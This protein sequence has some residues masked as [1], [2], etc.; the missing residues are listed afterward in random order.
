M[1]FVVTGAAVAMLLS[2]ASFAQAPGARQAADAPA[3]LAMPS[4]AMPSSAMPS[5][6]TPGAGELVLPAG[7]E[8]A[9]A[10]STMIDS[11]RN[12]VGDRFPLSVAAD[13]RIDGRVL[14]PRGTRAVGEIAWR[15][16]LGPLYESE[17]MYVVLR[18]L[19]LEGT[20]IPVE[21]SYRQ[22]G[23]GATVAADA[24][25]MRAGPFDGAFAARRATIPAGRE[26][27]ARIAYPV[28][29]EMPGASAP[30]ISARF[31]ARAAQAAWDASSDEA[32]CR[33]EAEA[34]ANGHPRRLARLTGACLRDR[35]R[36]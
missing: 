28:P 18:H 35:R 31:D 4:S 22:D 27:V 16:G 11:A 17:R 19:E 36:G 23:D 8:I 20:R 1:K 10:M 9:L 29:F 5:S 33:R 15:A 6:A 7:T 3:L 12:R 25:T 21:G 34:R 14:I 30:R 2:P 13:V 24:G 26:L 32:R